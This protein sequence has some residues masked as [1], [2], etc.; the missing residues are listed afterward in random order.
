[1]TDWSL[2]VCL[3]RNKSN[4]QS[5]SVSRNVLTYPTVRIYFSWNKA[6]FLLFCIIQA[7]LLQIISANTIYKWRKNPPPPKNP[8]KLARV[9]PRDLES[10][11]HTASFSLFLSFKWNH[12]IT[13]NCTVEWE[14]CVLVMRVTSLSSLVSS[15][16]EQLSAPVGLCQAWQWAAALQRQGH[17]LIQEVE[18]GNTG[19]SQRFSN[20]MGGWD[21][22]LDSVLSLH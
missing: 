17:K 7:K 14:D 16:E 19:C 2:S 11:W 5:Y 20:F 22:P 18:W 12:Y 6:P 9:R 4:P 15:R 8:P 13:H 10:M 21:F 3:K 1:M